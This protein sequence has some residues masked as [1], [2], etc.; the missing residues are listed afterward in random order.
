MF[1]LGEVSFPSP[2]DVLWLSSY[3]CLY[4]GLALLAR[5]RLSWGV[6]SIWLDGLEGA[7]ALTALAVAVVLPTIL[8]ISDGAPIGTVLTNLAYPVADTTLLA[9][10]G[11][12]F[13]MTGGR[14]GSGC[15]WFGAGVLVLAIGDTGFLFAQVSGTYAPGIAT[16]ALFPAFALIVA[17]AAW[18][19]CGDAVEA[20]PSGWGL[21]TFPALFLALA[22]GV[23][24][25]DQIAGANRLA[26]W[27]ALGAIVVAFGR[28]LM[29]FR[30]S[31]LLAEARR[32]SVT[33]DLTGL[34][35]RRLFFDDLE[36]SLAL[37]ERTAVILIDLDGFKEL[38]DALG[39]H[40]GDLLLREI[41]PRLQQA[42]RRGDV[43]ARL[44]GDEFAILL[45]LT[46]REVAEGV[47]RR[48][49][50]ALGTPF[51]I[52]GVELAVGASCGVAIAPENGESADLLMQRA[53]I[54]MYEAKA[55]RAGVVVY[56]GGH[57]RHSRERLQLAGEVRRALQND[58]LVLHYQPIGDLASGTLRGV[59]ALVR[60]QH[61]RHGL[62]GP[63]A[64]LPA[65]E[66]TD[67]ARDLSR[68]VLA[69]AAQQ[70]VA[71]RRAGRPLPV[72][73][74]L[75]AVDLLDTGLPADIAAILARY[76]AEPGDITLEMTETVLLT[77][78]DRARH[79]VGA[80]RAIGLTVA[81]DD[82][83]TG[84]SSLTHLHRIDVDELKIDRSFIVAMADDPAALAI[85][86]STIDLA[87]GLGLHVVGE[88][89][90][91]L[92]Q[93]EALARLGCDWVQG[94]YLSRPLPSDELER[95]LSTIGLA[96]RD[97]AVPALAP[98]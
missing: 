14:P 91:E 10:L 64:F 46:D 63:G 88:G 5:E 31:Q 90:E 24:A 45:P 74:N 62:L 57:D 32:L 3:P 59:E 47:A 9:F 39:H 85:V 37:H 60:W 42:V 53:D 79:V 76:D 77:D 15:T 41:G 48:A 18:R 1:N 8:T 55:N 73:V 2:A 25:Y 97:A 51:T 66:R 68:R 49:R 65:V 81:L 44:G 36:R 80:L 12:L 43:L 87:H 21:V 71:W 16:D 82:F 56:T 78:A 4:A 86:H 29:T 30:E 35:N 34:A 40:A 96:L 93:L 26:V 72:A 22:V 61:P 70:A 75:S 89:V 11:A 67:L 84:Y 52:E 38:N 7:L 20:R 54:A 17:L 92:S 83:G 95:E 6:R 19:D 50:A 69:L 98:V 27:L 58:E 28:T 23:L 33:D 94:Y 13:G